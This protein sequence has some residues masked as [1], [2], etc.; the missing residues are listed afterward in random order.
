MGCQGNGALGVVG[1]W[2]GRGRR[3]C[4]GS[5]CGGVYGMGSLGVVG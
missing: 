3:G 4:G 5:S 1:V 2:S